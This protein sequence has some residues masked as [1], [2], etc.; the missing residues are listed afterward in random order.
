MK[1]IVSII[2]VVILLFSLTSCG[3]LDFIEK[4]IND[5]QNRYDEVNDCPKSS[6]HKAFYNM[7]NNLSIETSYKQLY[8][9]YLSALAHA[10]SCGCEFNF[11]PLHK[12]MING[13]WTNEDGVVFR[14]I[15]A[16]TDYNNTVTDQSLRMNLVSSASKGGDY[17]YS[18]TSK[19]EKLVVNMIDNITDDVIENYIISFHED[20]I[21]L[22]NLIENK[23]YI[24]TLDDS[25]GRVFKSLAKHAYVCIARN[26]SII[27]DADITVC[28]VDYDTFDVYVTTTAFYSGG[29]GVTKYYRLYEVDGYYFCEP[30]KHDYEESNIDLLEL[31]NKLYEYMIK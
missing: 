7:I 20:S 11:L 24:L 12:K 22:E 13:L 30:V 6:E 3:L 15:E 28:Y 31:N 4:E 16:Y 26:L 25:V 29:F 21:L 5:A 10:N 23:T 18:F 9:I 2:L 14:V 8:S 1:K 19:S 27:T 17:L